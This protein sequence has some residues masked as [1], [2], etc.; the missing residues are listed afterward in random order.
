VRTALV[1]NIKK[2]KGEWRDKTLEICADEDK[3]NQPYQFK[4][5]LRDY[6]VPS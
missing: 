6:T 3:I 4:V 5:M 2:M 1:N